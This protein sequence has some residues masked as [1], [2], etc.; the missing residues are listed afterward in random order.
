MFRDESIIARAKQVLGIKKFSE[1]NLKKSFRSLI[2]KYHPDKVNSQSN[3]QAEILIEGYKVL[4]GEIKP[5]DCKL[6]EDDEL[7]SSLLPEGEEPVDLGIK[8]EDWVKDRFYDFVK[9]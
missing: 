7:V 4:K 6:L 9:P 2:Y 3:K 1:S 8:Y 5:S